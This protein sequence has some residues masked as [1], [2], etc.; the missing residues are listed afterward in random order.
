M[1]QAEQKRWDGWMNAH[2]G[3]GTRRERVPEGVMP[4]IEA[5]WFVQQEYIGKLE[6]TI[7]LLKK[8]P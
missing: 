3:Y 5:A 4:W 2:E 6:E 8:F 1:N 7:E